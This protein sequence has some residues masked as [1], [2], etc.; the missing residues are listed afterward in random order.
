MSSGKEM[1]H[2]CGFGLP[3]GAA[4]GREECRWQEREGERVPIEGQRTIT[5]SLFL[6]YN[7][8]NRDARNWQT[9]FGRKSHPVSASLS[10]VKRSM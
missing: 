6:V 7:L 5:L 1:K 10:A 4:G 3:S 9:Y 2:R 8:R